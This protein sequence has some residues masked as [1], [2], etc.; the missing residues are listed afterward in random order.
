MN[1]LAIDTATSM[2]IVTAS[3]DGLVADFTAEV[4]ISHSAT[5]FNNIDIALKKIGIEI[6][7]LNIL[8]V[9]IGPGSFTGIRIAVTTA[10]ML[11]Q[12]LK[13]PLVG[14]NTQL[15]FAASAAES[16]GDSDNLLVAFNAKKGRVFGALYRK[17]GENIIPDEIVKPGDYTIEH[18]LQFIE[19]GEKAILI[20]N[21][22]RDYYNIIK[23]KIHDHLLLRN[24]KPSG[25]IICSLVEKKYLENEFISDYRQLL[26]YYSRRS[27]AEILNP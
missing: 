12:V 14:I 23:S 20:G 15:M 18:L 26:P 22:C 3:A 10:R 2:E 24:Y 6:N 9:G 19:V 17:N 1:I 25:R 8:G 13:L 7:G 5:L 21:G 27:D 11:A 4:N 16:A